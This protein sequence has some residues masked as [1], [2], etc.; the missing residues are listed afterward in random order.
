LTF[1]AGWKK[2]AIKKLESM[3]VDRMFAMEI[4]ITDITE[5]HQNTY[6]VAGWNAAEQRMVRPL[7]NGANWTAELLADTGVCAG[8]IIGMTPNGVE[9]NSAF[10]HRIE[11][12]PID[13]AKIV[14]L[15]SGPAAW[16]G[17]NAPPV[18]NTLSAAFQRCVETT[19]VWDGARKGAYVK[20][21]TE[22]G[23]LGAV[24]L[25]RGGLRFLENDYKGDRTLRAYLTDKES[26]YNLP[27]VAKNLRE[28][29]RTG[30]V[31]AVNRSLPQSGGLHV[32][33]GL[34]RA[35][36]A[37]PEKCTVMINGVYW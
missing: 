34:A 1:A 11:D 13:A 5:M 37:Q 20:M 10:P 12:T 9:P 14:L 23:S 22:I 7:P 24:R 15:K 25:D 17:A 30:T 28:L 19:G 29:Y 21:G 16:F 35:W 31:S 33:V 6:C 36:P 32:R 27:V 2:V 26:C 8:T 18:R 3:R 4:L